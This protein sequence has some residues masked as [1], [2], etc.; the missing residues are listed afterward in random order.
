MGTK[1]VSSASTNTSILTVISAILV[2]VPIAILCVLGLAYI[3]VP[4]H[5]PYHQRVIEQQGEI[6]LEN[7]L[8]ELKLA[9]LS[10]M[11]ITLIAID[12]LLEKHVYDEPIVFMI[13]VVGLMASI[14]SYQK[15]FDSVMAARRWSGL[16]MLGFF[17]E[18]VYIVIAGP[19]GVHIGGICLSLAFA[20]TAFA[21][22]ALGRKVEAKTP[23]PILAVLAISS[24]LG[25]GL[26]F[27][28]I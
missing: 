21:S 22:R 28:G 5:L 17:V 12:F 4:G 19:I 25:S 20:Y 1:V 8:H 26:A 16:F 24:A 15:R 6:Y 27:W 10:G 23:W 13:L 11:V 18:L 14:V 9:C 2:G 7:K 3:F